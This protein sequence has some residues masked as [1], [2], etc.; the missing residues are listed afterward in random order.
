MERLKIRTGIL[1]LFFL[2]FI[3]YGCAADNLDLPYDVN[4]SITITNVQVKK[5]KESSIRTVIF[6][7]DKKDYKFKIEHWLYNDLEKIIS[8]SKSLNKDQWLY[9][10]IVVENN[11]LISITYSDYKR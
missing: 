4:N 9:F 7:K 6:T 3:L 5:L 8:T 1:C 2:T 11:N 10:D